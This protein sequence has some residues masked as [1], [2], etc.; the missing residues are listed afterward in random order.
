M[1]MN[2]NNNQ[3]NSLGN[4]IENFMKHLLFISISV[5]IIIICYK[6]Y[7][8]LKS[9]SFE[10]R[11]IQTLSSEQLE[12]KTYTAKTQFDDSDLWESEAISVMAVGTTAPIMEE[13]ET[14]TVTVVFPLDINSATPDELMQINGIGTVIAN[15]IVEYRNKYGYFYDIDELLNVEGIGEKKLSDLKSYIFISESLID[16][17]SITIT[18]ETT[19]P[20]TSTEISESSV[21][22]SVTNK[23]EL[24]T[25]DNYFENDEGYCPDFPLDLNTA[26][27]TD[28]MYIDGIGEITA[29]A[30]VDY[31]NKFG[32][33]NVYDLLNVNGI[34][35]AKLD[36]IMPF[37]YVDSD[38]IPT[39]TKIDD[40]IPFWYDDFVQKSEN[41][42]EETFTVINMIYNVDINTCGKADLM[43]LPGIDS[44]LADNIINLRNQIG[45]FIKIEE[46]SLVEGMTND[47]LAA[48]WNYVYVN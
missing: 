21:F 11:P 32:F 2:Q 5:V 40:E 45:Y 41:I 28:L 46:L 6:F 27:V 15:R 16:E 33:Y 20:T 19:T 42:S 26:S 43:Q 35:E 29:N 17:T 13:S 34:G 31:A 24:I 25:E 4:I 44:S 12:G 14:E 22:T 10:M 48:I 30:I 38:F 18:A 23:T 39:Q 47:K 9:E 37:V 1:F 8:L 7:K 3:N 36:S